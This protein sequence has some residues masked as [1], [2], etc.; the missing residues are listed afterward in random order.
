MCRVAAECFGYVAQDQSPSP[1]DRAAPKTWT[2]ATARGSEPKAHNFESRLATSPRVS[3]NNIIGQPWQLARPA[4]FA[5]SS[6]GAPRG[7]AV[8]T[9]G[10]SSEA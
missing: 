10:T 1:W 9:Y 6:L 7:F 4:G 3:G 2:V 8:F 5:A